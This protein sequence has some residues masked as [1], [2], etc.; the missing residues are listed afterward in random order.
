MIKIEHL[1]KDFKKPIRGEGVI[2]MFKTPE[3]AS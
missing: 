2:G 1:T 3:F